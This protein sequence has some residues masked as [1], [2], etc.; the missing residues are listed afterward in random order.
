MFGVMAGLVPAIHVFIAS[1]GR[2]D[3]DARDKRG[4]DGGASGA[5]GIRFSGRPS[6]ATLVQLDGKPVLVYAR[7][8][9]LKLNVPLAPPQH[10]QRIA[11]RMF[12]FC[13]SSSSGLSRIARVC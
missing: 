6:R 8:F 1:R 10:G 12:C 7:G 3:V 2:R 9:N 11:T 13:S 4:H 5:T